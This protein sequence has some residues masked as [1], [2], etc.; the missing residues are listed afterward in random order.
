MLF[1]YLKVQKVAD[2][3]LESKALPK[4][5]DVKSYANRSAFIDK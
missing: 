3:F 5:V 4:A 2:V 1:K